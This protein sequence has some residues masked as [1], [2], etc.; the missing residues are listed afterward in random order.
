MLHDSELEL[1]RWIQELRSPFLDHFFK[2][3]DYFDRQEFFFILVPVIWLCVGWR[4]GL[5]ILYAL[6]LCNYT[7]NLLKGF[8]LSPRPFHLD[9]QVGVI[10]T[11][12]LGFPSGAAQNVI[13]LS[14][15]LLNSWKS[16][17]RW[18]AAFL[19]ILLI[20]FSRVY[21]GLHFPSDIVAGWFVGFG[22]LAIYMYGFPTLEKR[23]ANMSPFSRFMTS[24]IA[25][26]LLLVCQY[27]IPTIRITGILMGVGTG[28]SF[29][30]SY[31]LFFAM[32]QS[33]LEY[34]GRSAIG[35]IG[36]FSCYY[37]LNALI[38]NTTS[39]TFLKFFLLGLWLSVGT[40]LAVRLFYRNRLASFGE[41]SYE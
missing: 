16:A 21:L 15:I 5:R 25:P 33:V 3:L 36:S 14:G 12:G 26:L 11:S 31:K 9:P 17:W 10:Q 32:P 29:I 23:L 38:P 1:I 13:L 37:L 7:N 41:P 30:T 6:L 27:S 2:F 39:T 34:L 20:S 18:L 28:L 24:Q 40:H 19:Y 8:F 22:L 4:S 35:I